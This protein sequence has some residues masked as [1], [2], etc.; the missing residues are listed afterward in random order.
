MRNLI[1]CLIVSVFAF[2]K[3]YTVSEKDSKI[4]FSITKLIW[5]NVDGEFT[6]FNGTID[7]N[8][9]G[10]IKK[11]NGEIDSS[12]VLT[13][14][15]LRDKELKSFESMLHVKKY[16]KIKFETVSIDFDKLVANLTIKNIT[17]KISFDI[18]SLS[19]SKDKIEIKISTEVLREA[20]N[21]KGFPVA[22]NSEVNIIGKIVAY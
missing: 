12:S 22:V 18:D 10:G 19:A 8:S 6:K 21:I 7:A 15:A 11:I 13:D 9:D 14:S 5:I 3:I 20:F 4:S 17:K 16:P 1:I 2:A